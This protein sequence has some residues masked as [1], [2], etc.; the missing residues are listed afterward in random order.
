[1]DEKRARR[2]NFVW[3]I[4][5]AVLPLCLAAC[6]SPRAKA[7]EPLVP[8]PITDIRSGIREFQ[9]E[10]GLIK[11]T[12]SHNKVTFQGKTGEV[13][14]FAAGSGYPQ[15][16]LRDAATILPASRLFYDAPYLSSWLIEH[17][18]FQKPDGGLEDWIDGRGRSDKNTTET[19][20]ETS[21]VRAASDIVRVLGP[22]WLRR[23]VAGTI[24]L[25]RLDKAL[26]WVVEQ[27]FDREHGLVKGAHTADWGDVDMNL[28]DQRAIYVDAG[29]HWTCDIY[30]QAQFYGA[31]LALAGMLEAAGGSP[32]RAIAWR[33][34]AAEVKKNADRWL[35]Q[36]DRGYYRVHV[37]LDGLS[38]GFDEDGMFPMGG[39]A[40]AALSGLASDE[41]CRKIFAAAV[42]R[43]GEFKISTIGGALLP[44]Y[45]KGTFK[46]PMMDDPYEYQNGGQWDWFGAK[47]VRAMFERGSSRTARDKLL[48]IAAKNAANGGFHEWDTPDGQGRGSAF[49]SGSAGSLALALVEGYFGVVLDRDGLRLEPKLGEDRAA[50]NIRVPAAGVFAAYEHAWDAETGTL[51]FRF[52]SDV[53]KSGSV[54]LLL[55][56]ALA[57]KT[58]LDVRLDGKKADFRIERRGDEAF[59]VVETDFLNHLLEIRK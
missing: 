26:Q 21:A 44:P 29:T 40:E 14:G 57:G 53:R 23:A 43:Q 33:E 1:V 18:A 39:N 51:R 11:A 15:I 41:Q 12:L 49:Y 20:Q 37:H 6:G 7:P 46:H 58:R 2:S 3:L 19:D 54:R 38:H 8:G 32:E 24:V 30:D 31:A 48:E 4:A 5:A 59:L 47:L 42:A 50:V 36:E 28:P 34:R 13:S 22:E 52:A 10:L 25:E 55:P 56:A 35:W 27:R 45:P 9:A 17:L 16:W